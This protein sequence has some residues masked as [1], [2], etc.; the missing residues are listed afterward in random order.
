MKK[1]GFTPFLHLLINDRA[2][3]Y[4]IP[5]QGKSLTPERKAAFN[6]GLYWFVVNAI[7][8]SAMVDPDEEAEFMPVLHLRAQNQIKQA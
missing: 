3:F 4:Q 8:Q 5:F 6:Y 2:S 7:L 1:G